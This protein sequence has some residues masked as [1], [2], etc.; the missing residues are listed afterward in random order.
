[1][2]NEM[3]PKEYIENIQKQR[4]NSNK[5]ILDCLAGAIDRLEKA[6]PG[7]GS[8]LMEFIQN[9]DDVK[10]LSL[11]IE[12][13]SNSVIRIWNNGEPFSYEDVESICKV[14]RSSKLPT[15]Y[16]GYL[17]VGFKAVFLISDCVE[18][19]SGEFSFKFDKNYWENPFHIPW[20]II[21]VWINKLEFNNEHRSYTTLFNLFIKENT[22]IEK[23]REEIKPEHLNNRILL[24]LRNIK[25]IEIIDT[26]QNYK[27]KLLKLKSDEISDYEISQIEEY[28]NG[29]LK[30]S[31]KWLVFRSV[32]P[33]PPE[34]KE[35]YI[36]KE[37]ERESVE[38]REVAV[39]FA[40]GEENDLI[41]E[42]RGTA[43][44]GVFSFL[45]LKEIPSG[46][47]F[48]IQGDF[49][50]PPGRGEIVH[51]SLWNEWLAKEIYELIT[52]KCISTFLNH[53]KWKMNF[54]EVLYPREGGHELFEKYIKKPLREYLENKEVLVAEDG[55]FSKPNELIRV[56]NEI[57]ELLTDEDLN[58]LY[59]NKKIIH[60]ECKTHPDLE[61]KIEKLPSDV[62][63]FLNTPEGKQLI[64][65]KVDL[66]DIDW[67]KKLF[68]AFVNKYNL[69][70]FESLTT[71]YMKKHD[72][73]WDDMRDF[74]I[75]IVL[76]ED[77]GLAKIN[78]CFTNLQNL[79]IPEFIR[80]KLKIVHPELA[81]DENFKRFVRKLNEVRYSSFP[82][83]NKVIEELTRENIQKIVERY[84]AEELI[85][86]KWQNLNDEDKIR[87]IRSLKDL[88]HSMYLSIEN[89]NFLTLKSKGGEWIKPEELIFSQEY[90]PEEEIE[91]LIQKG[92]LDLPLKFLSPEFI[93]NPSNN[94]EIREWREFFKKLGVNKIV[95]EKKKEWVQRIAI[96]TSL[97]YEKEK[98]REGRELGESERLGYDIES[99]SEQEE[100]FIEVK[101]THESSYDI[102]LTVNEF[103]CL[104]DKRDKYFI[105]VVVNAFKNS[106]HLYI[107]KG[108]RLLQIEDIKVIIPFDRWT[109]MKEEE[110]QP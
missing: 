82:P 22:L 76:T 7:Y 53:N 45:P 19:Y 96:L 47:N 95:E 109:T 10:S 77:Y 72:E 110:F 18:I 48:L 42:S 87:K 61:S 81:Q 40:L 52:T 8:F 105:Y 62:H 63:S 57:R 2:K 66:K 70:Y 5:D 23:L 88:C 71:R 12:F 94:N 89:Y 49:L 38:Q 6:F 101:G 67:F 44:I 30:N 103:R 107:C 108:D 15:D 91:I 90:N 20:Q 39:A 80:D 100:R 21:P 35:D 9:A 102:F 36:T 69:S 60:K 34:V 83:S 55:S 86:Q 64:K 75:P 26:V 29:N 104:R 33:V 3:T 85:P 78:E 59:P 14:G 13:F 32:C 68:S 46:L 25:E 98:G 11:K 84:E 58:I 99:R 56:E 17:G 97:K 43:H 65:R 92:L 24:F 106:P 93:Q 50:T 27:R 79:S 51:D 73:F 37:W 74:S 4:L 54:T 31:S 1:M 41:K 16:I 28:E